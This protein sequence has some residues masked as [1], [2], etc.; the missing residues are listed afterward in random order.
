MRKIYLA[1]SLRDTQK[2][3][4]KIK[5]LFQQGKIPKILLISGE[6]GA[7]KT[8]FIR[9]L[10]KAYGLKVRVASPTFILWQ[11]FIANDSKLHHLDLYRLENVQELLKLDFQKEL[12]D[13][14]SIFLVE[15]GEKMLEYLQKR[16]IKFS[17]LVI[18]RLNKRQRFFDLHL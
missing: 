7:G 4:Q 5:N 16:Q 2:I 15:W 10:I 11:T 17:H 3:A 6:L 1:R 9:F 18:I 12:K 14:K 13:Q 8:T